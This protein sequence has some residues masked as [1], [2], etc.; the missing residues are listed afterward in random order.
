MWR[1]QLPCRRSPVRWSGFGTPPATAGACST[2]RSGWRCSGAAGGCGPAACA[3]S[4]GH[5]CARGTG[6]VRPVARRLEALDPE[7]L[8]EPTVPAPPGARGLPRIL[9]TIVLL[10]GGGGVVGP[11]PRGRRA[12]RG[13]GR[14]R[15]DLRGRPGPSRGADGRAFRRHRVSVRPPAAG[16]RPAG[17]GLPPGTRPAPPPFLPSSPRRARGQPPIH[18]KRFLGGIGLL[19]VRSARVHAADRTHWWTELEAAPARG[20]V[21]PSVPGG[22]MGGPCAPGRPG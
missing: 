5:G 15:L 18:A 17:P 3:G 22:A 8:T 11:N 14:A 7:D 10:P 6:C 1:V 12:G 9:S 21:S 13:A 2:S 20:M 19:L 4:P 16:R